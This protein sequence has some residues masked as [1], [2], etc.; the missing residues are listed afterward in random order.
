MVGQKLGIMCNVR[1]SEKVFRLIASMERVR[2]EFPHYSP[3]PQMG[4]WGNIVPVRVMVIFLCK[5][6]QNQKH[7]E[8]CRVQSKIM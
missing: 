1:W 6:E 4:K 5:R 7:F 8:F 3:N 2:N